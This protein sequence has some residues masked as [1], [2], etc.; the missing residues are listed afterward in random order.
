MNATT[1]IIAAVIIGLFW[2]L[3]AFEYRSYRID[4]ARQVLFAIRDSL[5]DEA[6][7]DKIEFSNPAYGMTR[8]TLNGMIR[9][10]H[11]LSFVRL[12]ILLIT[13]KYI[14]KSVFIDRY[15]ERFKEALANAK[16]DERKLLE[17]TL[18]KAHLVVFDHIVHTSLILSVTLLPLVHVA[19]LL[20]V[21][22]K[23]RQRVSE[24]MRRTAWNAIDA[25]ANYIDQEAQSHFGDFRGVR[26]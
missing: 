26:V 7:Q 15:N 25:E 4:L 21:L 2:W 5:F 10:T 16:E 8:S 14:D 12:V 24:S 17:A 6:A 11:E 9:F 1:M 19:R 13:Q 23:T 3:F 22:V 18:M 20:N